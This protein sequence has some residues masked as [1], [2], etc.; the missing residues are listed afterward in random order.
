MRFFTAQVPPEI[1]QKSKANCKTV[2]ITWLSMFPMIFSMI[3]LHW[4]N[5]DESIITVLWNTFSIFRFDVLKDGLS[6]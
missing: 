3:F 1:K 6:N 2:D 5:I 4:Y